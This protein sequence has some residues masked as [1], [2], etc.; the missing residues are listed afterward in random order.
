M[1]QNALNSN[2]E[3]FEKSSK[4]FL[5]N[6]EKNKNKSLS[7][8]ISL[9]GLIVSFASFDL[10]KNRMNEEL[11]NLIILEILVI[12]VLIGLN[13]YRKM[14]NK[15]R[16]V[17]EN[18]LNISKE[19][20]DGYTIQNFLKGFFNRY[21]KEL[22][23]FGENHLQQLQT[24]DSFFLTVQG[25]IVSSICKNIDD[26]IK[27]IEKKKI[28]NDKEIKEFKESIKS[29]EYSD[30]L[31]KMIIAYSYNDPTRKQILS[32][33]KIDNNDLIQIFSER[34]ELLQILTKKIEENI[35]YEK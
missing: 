2:K 28:L 19:Y 17:S 1:Y 23:K 10:I 14:N 29:T 3:I 6:L 34:K 30:S 22:N 32:E 13:N 26:L 18:L 25:S 9:I 7:I 4:T 15:I 20:Y 21:V 35:L 8:T 27:E 33:G 5:S 11:S 16:N 31:F 12:I 24:L